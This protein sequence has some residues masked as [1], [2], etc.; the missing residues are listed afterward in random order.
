MLHGTL[1][2]RWVKQ[3]SNVGTVV[4]FQPKYQFGHPEKWLF[5]LSKQKFSGSKQPKQILFN[6]EN[7]S[8]A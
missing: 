2:S 8:T 4:L 5:P 1:G 7:I 6:F 3:D